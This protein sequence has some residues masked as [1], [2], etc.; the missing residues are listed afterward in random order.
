MASDSLSIRD[1]SKRAPDLT[2]D[3]VK[4]DFLAPRVL[5]N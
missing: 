1:V 4:F 2:G 5:K 3:T